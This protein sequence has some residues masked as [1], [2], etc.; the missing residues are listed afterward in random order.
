LILTII[1]LKGT[2]F[3]FIAIKNEF[4]GDITPIFN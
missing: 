1:P 3:Q 2:T 4:F